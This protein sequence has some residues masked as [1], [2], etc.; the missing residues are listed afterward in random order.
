MFNDRSGKIMNLRFYKEYVCHLYVEHI[1][2]I[3]DVFYYY[4]E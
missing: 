2:T 1:V 3:P 4:L